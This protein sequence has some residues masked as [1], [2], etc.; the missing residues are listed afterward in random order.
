MEWCFVIICIK[1]VLYF[2]ACYGGSGISHRRYISKTTFPQVL[3]WYF[4][5]GYV[6]KLLA[7]GEICC[8]HGF[9]IKL[10]LNLCPYNMMDTRMYLFTYRS[11]S[12][13]IMLLDPVCLLKK[14]EGY[15]ISGRILSFFSRLYKVWS[16]IPQG[17]VLRL[18]I[19]VIYIN[20]FPSVVKNSTLFI[21]R[22]HKYI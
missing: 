17:L 20:D 16:G 4:W 1:F 2:M 21:R 12:Y 5:S 3:P 13:C 18:L 10:N 8:Q 19:F 14:I 7:Y 22:R 11:S 6:V 15:G 9:V